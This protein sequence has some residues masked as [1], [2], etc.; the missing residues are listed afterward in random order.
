MNP[1]SPEQPKDFNQPVAY[2]KDGNPLYAHPPVSAAPTVTPVVPQVVQM[3][4]AADPQMPH[5]S[6]EAKRRHQESEQKHPTLNLSD[7]DYIINEVRRHPIGL[8]SILGIAGVLI[9]VVVGAI[10]A[11]P[12]IASQSTVDLPPLSSFLVP[13]LLFILLIVLGGYIAVY[14]YLSNKFFLTNE[15]VIQEIQ[16]SL[17]SRHE[18]TVS[19][20]NIE[21]ASYRQQG[22]IQTMFDYGSIR[23]S[24]EGEETTYRFYYVSR[25]KKQIATLNNAVESFKNGRPVTGE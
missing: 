7:G 16:T 17:F 21:D 8:V 18:Q 20:A 24:T 25:P 5:I 22:I 2:D 11:Y 3:T 4:R 1:N 14:V 9:L 19:L 13:A 15:S 6:D 12:A 10:A 23:L